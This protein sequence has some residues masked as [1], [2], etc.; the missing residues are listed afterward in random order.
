MI[1]VLGIDIDCCWLRDYCVVR[2]RRA[3]SES[4]LVL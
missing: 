1:L 4:L 3:E 2:E